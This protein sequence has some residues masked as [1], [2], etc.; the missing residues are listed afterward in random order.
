MHLGEALPPWNSKD[1]KCCLYKT[2]YVAAPVRV[3]GDVIAKA[4]PNK[5]IPLDA[6]TRSREFSWFTS[7]KFLKRPVSSYR[8]S[9]VKFLWGDLRAKVVPERN[10]YRAWGGLRQIPSSILSRILCSDVASWAQPSKTPKIKTLRDQPQLTH[11]TPTN[12]LGSWVLQPIEDMTSLETDFEMHAQWQGYVE[13]PTVKDFVVRK[14]R[15]IALI[16]VHGTHWNAIKCQERLGNCPEA[17]VR[18]ATINL[19]SHVWK[20]LED[21][22]PELNCVDLAEAYVMQESVSSRIFVRRK[23][24]ICILPTDV[25]IRNLRQKAEWAKKTDPESCTR[26]PRASYF[27]K[28]RNVCQKYGGTRRM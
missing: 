2:L 24:M 10:T 6:P 13:E 15:T 18:Q 16:E 27:E 26:F 25:C 1:K 9:Y 20:S 4:T 17:V 12:L 28:R 3:L 5:Q 8:D 21:P 22:F 19:N 14:V 11:V 23:G 7:D